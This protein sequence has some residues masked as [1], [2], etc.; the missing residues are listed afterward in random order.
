MA[1]RRH[2]PAS[3]LERALRELRPGFA[4]LVLFSC[5]I[6]LLILASPLYM[7][8][9]YDRVLAS[10]RVETLVFLTLITAAALLGLG[11]LDAVRGHILGR[12]GRWLDRRLTP[13]L[14]TASLRRTLRG[15]A[16]GGQA[17]RDLATV[18]NVLAGPG[19]S[20]L[21][22]APWAPVF[23][24]I[25]ALMHPLLGLV[26]VGAALALLALA[27]ANEAASRRPCETRRSARSARCSGPRRRFAMPTSSWPW[28]CGATSSGAGRR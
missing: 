4:M 13:D 26:A 7:W 25:I 11:A 12:M 2:A 20:A 27:V 22:D 24:A 28:A 18:R 17:L 16:A 10:G 21:L 15:E 19:V 8:Q 1:R 3:P 23:I 6:N 5:G 9:I 14:I